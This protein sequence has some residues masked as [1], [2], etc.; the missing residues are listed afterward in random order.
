[1][2]PTRSAFQSRLCLLKVLKLDHQPV[3]KWDDTMQRKI[4][5]SRVIKR[6]STVVVRFKNTPRRMLVKVVFFPKFCGKKK[7]WKHQGE[8]ILAWMRGMRFVD[9]FWW[10]PLFKNKQINYRLVHSV[11]VCSL[12][13][14]WM[15]SQDPVSWVVQRSSRKSP[16]GIRS[17]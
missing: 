13:F 3:E 10:F 14:L 9:L 6:W 17:L 16:K 15:P 12:L 11:S 7:L 2:K 1:M 4:W 8:V 5:V